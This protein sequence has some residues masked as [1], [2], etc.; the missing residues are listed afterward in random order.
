MRVH[1]LVMTL[2]GLFHVVGYARRVSHVE[3]R[4]FWLEDIGHGEVEVPCTLSKC[5]NGS[6]AHCA[7]VGI[8]V[9][10]LS[11]FSS[12]SLMLYPRY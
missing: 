11:L 1:A 2:L 10:G 3:R 8:L 7:F 12:S 4:V 5:L 9:I 6:R